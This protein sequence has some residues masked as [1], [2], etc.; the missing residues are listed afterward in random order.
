MRYYKL[1]YP[2]DQ[3]EFIDFLGTE[4]VYIY[5]DFKVIVIRLCNQSK[6]EINKYL[7]ARGLPLPI[8]IYSSY[9]PTNT[10]SEIT[11]INK[12]FYNPRVREFIK[13]ME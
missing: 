7:A 10:Q 1:Y 12:I 8:Y 13:R 6:E 9:K 4:Q 11:T 3:P 2:I 5:R